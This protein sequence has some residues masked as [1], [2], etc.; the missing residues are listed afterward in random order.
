MAIGTPTILTAGTS[1]TNAISRT[2]AVFTPTAGAELF[3]T[4]TGRETTASA[5]A[6]DLTI[7]NSG[8]GSFA[9]NEITI[10]NSTGSEHTSSL[11]YA[12]TPVGAGSPAITFT[13]SENCNRWEWAVWEVSQCAD[14][15]DN[16]VTGLD[17]TTTPSTTLPSAPV[18]SSIVMGILASV[19]D[20]TGVS[21]G[22]GFTEL[23]DSSPG[24]ATT[25]EVEWKTGT[26][27][28]TVDWSGADTT[29]NLMIAVELTFEDLTWN[30][31]LLSRR[32]RS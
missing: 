32:R 28:T 8:T 9:W 16:S 14:T 19:A 30:P 2:T 11:W 22:S 15:I 23:Y 18:A 31:G 4:C 25:L 3:A 21:A 6:P 1:N 5:P 29:S 24:T 26:T 17:T 7:S 10:S 27:G 13:A 20:S 12:R